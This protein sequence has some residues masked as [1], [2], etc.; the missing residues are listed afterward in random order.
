MELGDTGGAAR[1]MERAVARA[2][3]MVPPTRYLCARGLLELRQRR[4]ADA[5]N[6]AAAILQ[7]APSS[8]GD[9]ARA[10]KAAAYLKG[11]AFLVEG[12]TDDAI[13][14]LS[15]AVTLEGG[16]YSI[17]RLGLARAYL[18]AKRLPEALAA[19][20]QSAG[21]LDL[22]KPELE[23]ELD[24]VRAILVQAEVQLAMNRPAEAAASARRFM[25]IWSRADGGLPD[26]SLAERI[27]Q[28]KQ[29]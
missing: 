7:N 12:K 13:A 14:E 9:F 3:E 23:L 10:E 2:P 24:R 16:E 26:R 25:E 21:P 17:Y 15:R 8:G 20:K 5:R 6:T 22:V 28:A 27:I 18:A 19:A 11:M 29:P 4:V 1:L